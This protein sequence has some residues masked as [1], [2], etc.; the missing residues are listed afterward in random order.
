VHSGHTMSCPYKIF[1]LIRVLWVENVHCKSVGGCFSHLQNLS[2]FFLFHVSVS[3]SMHSLFTAPTVFQK[4]HEFIFTYLRHS[5]TQ[6]SESIL[7]TEI[8]NKHIVVKGFSWSL[9]DIRIQVTQHSSI[10]RITQVSQLII[11]NPKQ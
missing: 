3:T 7:R 6:K 2:F 10:V 11:A 1:V 8:G 4:F 9:S 5:T